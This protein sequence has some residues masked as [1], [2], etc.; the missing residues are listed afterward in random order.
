MDEIQTTYIE[1]IVTD[2]GNGAAYC[3]N[4]GEQLATDPFKIPKTCPRCKCQLIDIGDIWTNNGGS[5]F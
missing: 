4:C 1:H 2:C 5:D 3:G